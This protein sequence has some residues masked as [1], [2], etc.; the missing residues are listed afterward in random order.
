MLFLK[1]LL[2]LGAGS[3]IHAVGDEQDM[4]KIGGG[5]AVYYL[6]HGSSSLTKLRQTP[7]VCVCVCV[8]FPFILDINGRTSRGHTRGK[9]HRISHPPS[10]CRACLNFSREKDS[11]IPFPRRPW[12]RI[13]CTNDFNRSPPVGSF[14]A[15]KIPFA[16]IE[17]KSQL[18]RGLRGTSELPGRPATIFLYR[19]DTQ[20][21]NSP[22][23]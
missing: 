7:N 11:A 12:S 3:V 15:R 6:L 20:E 18:V 17:L 2:F 16:G 19:A 1:L 22:D 9:S 8:F 21:G 23:C 5:C 14:L 4:R 10:F 13:L